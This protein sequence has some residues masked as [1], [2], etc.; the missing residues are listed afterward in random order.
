[1]IE[2]EQKLIISACIL[3]DRKIRI[4]ENAVF[5]DTQM[6][7]DIDEW[8]FCCYIQQMN[9]HRSLY[10]RNQMLCLFLETTTTS[11]CPSN[12]WNICVFTTRFE[13]TGGGYYGIEY[14]DIDCNQALSNITVVITVQKMFGA[15]F[16]KQY[17]SLLPNILIETHRETDTQIFYKWVINSGQIIDNKVS[18]YF[19]EAQFQLQGVN[20]SSKQRHLFSFRKCSMQ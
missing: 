3:S 18:P 17:N 8:N 12:T 14:V 9:R 2:L 20:Q 13:I 6:D 15:S 7:D 5:I 4:V 1:M 10:T 11:W 19:V 16:A